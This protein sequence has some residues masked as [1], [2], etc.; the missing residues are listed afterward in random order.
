M[1]LYVQYLIVAVAVVAAA[2]VSW[3]KLSGRHVL[4]PG[5]K[6]DGCAGCGS[7]EEHRR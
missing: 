3:R 6:P 2:W 7:E 4:K 1:S 5:H